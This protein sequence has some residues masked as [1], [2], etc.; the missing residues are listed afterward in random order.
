MGLQRNPGSGSK[1]DCGFKLQNESIWG[2]NRISGTQFTPRTAS[3]G[4]VRDKREQT[5]TLPLPEGKQSE[6][7]Q[8][9]GFEFPELNAEVEMKLADVETKLAKVRPQLEA[10][11]AKAQVEMEKAQ[12]DWCKKA[13]EFKKQ[14]LDT[15]KLQKQVEKAMHDAERNMELHFEF[16]NIDDDN[17]I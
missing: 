8:E 13:L 2:T 4:V 15:K 9:E 5:L 17:M 14:Q 10:A 7:E 11:M 12:K 1:A 16:T 3:I 6:L